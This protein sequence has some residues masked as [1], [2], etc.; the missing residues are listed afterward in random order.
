MKCRRDRGARHGCAVGVASR[1]RI[2]LFA[3]PV[4]IV[5]LMVLHRQHSAQEEQAMPAG[6]EAAILLD[7]QSV[8]KQTVGQL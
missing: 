8:T 2:K 4:E 3:Q 7:L 5:L 6:D 1:L